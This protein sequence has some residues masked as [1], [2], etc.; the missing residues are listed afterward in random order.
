MHPKLCISYLMFNHVTHYLHS[1]WPQLAISTLSFHI[2]TCYT[3]QPIYFYI[4]IWEKGFWLLWRSQ[5]F[6]SCCH[7]SCYF[8]LDMDSGMGCYFDCRICCLCIWSWNLLAHQNSAFNCYIYNWYTMCSYKPFVNFLIQ[9]LHL[10]C[11]FN[12]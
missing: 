11:N 8:M 9:F 7:Y 1:D 10:Q 12:F 6:G 4:G 3:T 5:T 2:F